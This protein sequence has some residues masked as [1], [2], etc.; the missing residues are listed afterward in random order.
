MSDRRPDQV[1]ETAMLLQIVQVLREEQKYET[2]AR[3]IDEIERHFVSAAS[4]S[5]R[6]TLRRSAA[7]MAFVAA[8]DKGASFE[9]VSERFRARC[10][11]GFIDI[12]SELAVLVEFAYA[13]CEFRQRAAG[14]RVLG[15]ARRKLAGSSMKSG[16]R[17]VRLQTKLMEQ[18][19]RRLEELQ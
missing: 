18:C 10:G 1:P 2:A 4:P 7:R 14:L 8:T 9:T 6:R 11:L 15:R 19:R 12:A 3:R 13:C 16:S 17:F 5:K